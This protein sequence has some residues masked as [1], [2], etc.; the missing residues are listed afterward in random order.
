MAGRTRNTMK[1]LLVMLVMQIITVLASFACRTLFVKLLPTEYLGLSGL[2]T[3]IIAILSLSELGFGN[4]IIIHLYKPLAENDKEQVCRL[5]N[6]YR[7]AYT[8]V[9]IFIIVCG[10]V[11]TPFLDYVVK[12]DT[13]IPHLKGYF[14]LFILQSASSYFFAY[15]S[16]LLTASQQEYICSVV[17]QSLGIVT[18]LLQILFLWVTHQYVSY[19]LVSIIIGLTNNIV[20]SVIAEKQFPYL[21]DN[22][23]LKLSKPQTKDMFKNVSSM[24]LHKV[25][26]VVIT[27]TDNILISSLVGII[28]TGLYSNYLLIVNVITQ[29][30]TIGLN[31]VSASIGDF[32]ARKNASEKKELFDA[33]QLIS[34]WIFGMSAICFACLFQPTITLWLGPEYLLDYSVV[35][36]VSI[37]FFING[38]LRVP[39]TFSDLN[40]IYV[41]TKFKPI[42]MAIMNLVVSVIC[43]KL[44]GLIGVFVGTLVSYIL[45]GLWVDPY[46]VFK[47]VFKISP[48][49][50][51]VKLTGQMILVFALG[52]ITYIIVALIPYYIVKV[53]VCVFVINGLLL[54]CFGWTKSFKFIFNRIKSSIFH[55]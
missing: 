53:L 19:L 25:G 34:M 48:M 7:K 50:Y 17:R 30:I 24:M 43:L 2:F 55:R 15:K 18:N 51:F 32:N 45:V 31:A 20:T 46:F 49:F 21:K 28:Y 8:A 1:N 26:N 42:A 52:V 6:F 12:N 38:I 41:K 4:V 37:N 54:L 9:G 3:N 14:L 16:A 35:L 47:E 27:S 44:W 36:I 33:L 22:R 23:K 40:G 5:M 39:G 29:I 11:L 10:L 13:D